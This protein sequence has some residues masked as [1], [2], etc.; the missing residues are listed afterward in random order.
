[1]PRRSDATPF[2]ILVQLVQQGK[3]MCARH[4]GLLYPNEEDA[5]FAFRVACS[6]IERHGIRD[7]TREIAS[8][9]GECQIDAFLHRIRVIVGRTGP[10]RVA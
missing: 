10:I 1:M 3:L 2:V 8:Q 4:P 6:R 7:S 9:S 5:A